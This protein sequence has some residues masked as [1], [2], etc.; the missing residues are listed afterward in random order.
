M[1]KMMKRFFLLLA[2]CL[3]GLSYAQYTAS[4]NG[5]IYDQNGNH[6]RVDQFKNMLYKHPKI[7]DAY[8]SG[9]MKK[10]FGNTLMIGGISLATISLASA[11]YGPAT[12]GEPPSVALPMIGGGMFIIGGLLKIGFKKK[13][14]FAVDEF[15]KLQTTSSNYEPEYYFVS[16][17]NGIGIKIN[18]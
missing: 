14:Q 18:F 6:V 9:R 5:V 16:N 13:I 4:R 17:Q 2:I 1:H 12:P 10:D 3:F 8:E 7:L 11:L 15:N